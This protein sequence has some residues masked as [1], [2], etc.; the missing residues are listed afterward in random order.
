VNLILVNSQILKF[1]YWS[2]S[3]DS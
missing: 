3:S 1:W 2:H